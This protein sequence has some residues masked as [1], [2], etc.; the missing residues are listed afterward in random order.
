MCVPGGHGCQQSIPYPLEL[1]LLI[2]VR[3]NVGAGN[4]TCVVWKTNQCF[5]ATPA[6]H[7]L[8]NES[9]FIKS[10]VSTREHI[11]EKNQMNF[12]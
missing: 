11:G 1:D 12:P 5:N 8:L 2:I 10:I 7:L 4:Q 9:K 3:H 6:L